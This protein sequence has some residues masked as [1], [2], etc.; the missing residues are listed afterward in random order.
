MESQLPVFGD[1][2]F[3]PGDDL[4]P[5]AMVEWVSKHGGGHQTHGAHS[6]QVRR[7]YTDRRTAEG[8]QLAAVIEALVDDLG[9]REVITTGQVILLDRIREK[10]ITLQQIGKFVDDQ[11]SLIDKESGELLAVLNRNY[12]AYSESLRRD[13]EALHGLNRR[14]MKDKAPSLAEIIQ[15]KAKVS[16]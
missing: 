3:Q 6:K 2:R 4:R 7:R 5:A 11:V 15:G 8:K 9:G 14:R 10:L 13:V 16:P 1:P 12:L